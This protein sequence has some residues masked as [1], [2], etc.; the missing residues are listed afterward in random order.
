MKKITL[1]FA[2]IVMAIAAQAA[3]YLGFKV[4][5]ISI[6]S[7][8]YNQPITSDLIKA[9]DTSQP[10]SVVYDH[11]TATLTFTNVK[12]S[13]TGSYNRA[14]LNESC[15]NLII[16]FE[17][18]NELEA[19]DAS[20]VRLNA[21][22]TIK[23]PNG[24]ALFYGGSE[25][26][27]TVGNG[28]RLTL[29]NAAIACYQS[30][31]AEWNES[32]D[33]T[34]GDTGNETLVIKNSRFTSGGRSGHSLK[35]FALLDVQSSY[36]HLLGE[37]T[38]GWPVEGLKDFRYSGD[39]FKVLGW[40]GYD[41][42]FDPTTKTFVI[43]GGHSKFQR[44]VIIA[45]VVDYL[46][47]RDA[48]PDANFAQ[49]ISDNTSY[50]TF[51]SA[52]VM[53]RYIFLPFRDD[54]GTGGHYAKIEANDRNI[55]SIKGI[56]YLTGLEDLY[57][58]NNS[59]TTA[60][61]SQNT[62]LKILN[63]DDNRLTSLN[64]S[65]CPLLRELSCA[66]NQL[67]SLNL[68]NCRNL[69]YAHCQNNQIANLQLPANDNYTL[70]S[71][72]C[73]N[74]KLTELNTFGI[75]YLTYLDCSHNEIEGDLTFYAGLSYLDC[76]H[77]KISR[78]PN[79][80]NGGR[81]EVFRC[82]DNQIVSLDMSH[83]TSL[84]NFYCQN[85][86]LTTLNL[87]WCSDLSGTVYA[88]GNKINGTGLDN[89]ITN[90]PALAGHYL[91]LVDHNNPN[92]ENACTAAQV[93][94]AQDQGWTIFHR[95]QS[96]EF[97]GTSECLNYDM[98]I[99]GRQ[100]CSHL[101]S[102]LDG[103]IE[104]VSGTWRYND[105]ANMLLLSNA[106]INGGNYAG[107]ETT[108]SPIVIN[109]VGDNTVT[110]NASVGMSLRGNINRITGFNS[111]DAHNLTVTGNARGIYVRG[112][113]LFLEGGLHLDAESRVYGI[114]GNN[115]TTLMVSDENTV[116]RTKGVAGNAMRGVAS[117]YLNDGL[118]IIEPAGT[119]FESNVCFVNNGSE[120]VNQWVT[121]SKKA[122]MQGDVN[123]DGI[124][125][126]ADVTALY[127]V[128]LDDAIV[129]GDAD[130]NGDGVVSGADVTALYNILLN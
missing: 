19:L 70:N 56:E 39:G 22:T 37:S 62:K 24:N 31:R 5:D 99:A 36:V 61:L 126:G 34:V 74:N 59:V 98:K 12:I 18:R 1:V 40:V 105:G 112:E 32:M 90:L 16:V 88:F 44:G 82:N 9:C 84:K 15:A 117:L 111:N 21:N 103:S 51:W 130:V 38:Y 79:L 7:D 75:K 119:S 35:N 122:G 55:T 25:D 125:S 26:A 115:S 41:V 14:I 78:I 33:G 11:S 124:V 92:E 87:K 27:L 4:A 2:L 8:N 104:G 73:Q 97:T 20:P 64:L 85:N 45:K 93:R 63:I 121:I 65:N 110:S 116:I 72:Q 58:N 46:N 108:K 42:V 101:A 10:F 114:L 81:I 128:L 23:S 94:A 60:D 30:G 66:N 120:V 118:E 102:N 68:S 17:G 95:W 28:A 71:L 106:T 127:N 113:N 52:A 67:P 29:D 123:G 83:C 57:L 109:V 6:T 54:V 129:A 13:R 49:A 50:Y 3:T 91:Y 77:N 107:I 100:L 47:D 80:L 43:D 53:L 96:E 86:L 69:V 89:L 76:S 48:F